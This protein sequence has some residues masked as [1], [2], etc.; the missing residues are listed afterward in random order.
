MGVNKLVR[1]LQD[2]ELVINDGSTP[3]KSLTLTLDMGDLSW[4][5]TENSIEILDRGRIREGGVL[6]GQ[7]L[8][9]NDAPGDISFSTRMNQLIG[10]TEDSEDDIFLY[11]MVNNLEGAFTSTLPCGNQ[12]A[13]QYVFT[14][15]DPCG[16]GSEA[17]TFDHVYK[18]EMTIGEGE[19]ANMINFTGRNFDT[20]PT[21]TRIVDG[22]SGSGG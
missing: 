22:G 7:V 12:F 16:T 5:E 14:V 6:V 4:T 11:E 9:G 20:K 2:G 17:I 15:T 1:N 13:L 19:D 8:K 21:V 3:A 10:F 18:T